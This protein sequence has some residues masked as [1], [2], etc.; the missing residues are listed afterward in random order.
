MMTTLNPTRDSAD[1]SAQSA[2]LRAQQRDKHGDRVHFGIVM[3]WSVLI[4]LGTA[5][6]NIVST[7]LL[8]YAILRIWAT[9]PTYVR[10]IRSP[11]FLI[12]VATLLWYSITLFW[13]ADRK[14]G[15]DELIDLRYQIPLLLCLWPILDRSRWILIGVCGSAVIAAFAQILQ[16]FGLDFGWYDAF[17]PD[18]FP[19]F[20]HPMST[21][22][23]QMASGCL[24][25]GW[26]LLGQ[27][28]RR[29]GGVG[30]L[31]LCALGLLLA[32]SR[33][34]WVTAGLAWPMSVLF[35][36]LA[37][38]RIKKADHA[39]QTEK[40]KK[41]FTIRVILT[42]LIVFIACFVIWVTTGPYVR[43]RVEQATTDIRNTIDH[44]DY[45]S[46]IGARLY[47]VHLSWTLFTD[48]PITGQGLGSYFVQARQMVDEN[49]VEEDRETSKPVLNT[50]HNAVL[51][52][53][54]ETGLIGFVLYVLFWVIFCIYA[55]RTWLK[56][57]ETRLIG[58]DYCTLPALVIGV[59]IAFLLDCQ[60]LSAPG[61]SLL[62]ILV[63]V[64]MPGRFQ[65]RTVE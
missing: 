4:I 56:T 27:G 45:R 5:P 35:G 34:S 25:I 24:A 42:I 17:V 7:A 62:V 47:Q 60:N 39:D 2:F 12:L 1:D 50:P 8:V 6:A 65:Q 15:F 30:V 18:R 19:G 48:K 11:M 13:S 53:M 41:S 59:F 29:W 31:A 64:S 57:S 51:Y 38:L 54:C 52:I 21:T 49:Q 63:A 33:A 61:A 40:W 44:E 20:V 16:R 22:I 26:I 14:Q 3:V 36:G 55:W 58:I 10:L 32:G 43:D 46:D 28:W 23:V 9:A 37:L